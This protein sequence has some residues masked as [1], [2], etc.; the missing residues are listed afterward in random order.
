MLDAL[1][2]KTGK[3]SLKIKFL[4]TLLEIPFKTEIIFETVKINLRFYL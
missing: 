1:S 3:V 4:S 2:K